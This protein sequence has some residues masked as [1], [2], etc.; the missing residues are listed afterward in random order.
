MFSNELPKLHVEALK[1]NLSLKGFYDSS[2]IK[3]DDNLYET[4]DV[5]NT[6]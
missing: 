5:D 6:F 1:M 2:A 4:R 3:I